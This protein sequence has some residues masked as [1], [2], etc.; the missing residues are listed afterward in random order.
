MHESPTADHKANAS[1]LVLASGGLDSTACLTFYREQ[2]YEI[3]AL[4]VDYGQGALVQERRAVQRIAAHYA[5]PL[6]IVGISGL[7]SFGSGF[8]PARNALLVT[9]ALS[10]VGV[11]TAS[12]ALGIHDGTSYPDCSTAFVEAVQRIF[13]IYTDGRVRLSCPFLSWLKPQ[14]WD[15]CQKAVVPTSL[16][17]SCERG[18][19]LPCGT[20]LS[21]KDREALRVRG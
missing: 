19:D 15:Y 18:G 9:A 10:R 21:C 8:I 16:T 6:S 4:F 11:T 5:V 3:E 13:D 14:I 7:A 20:C 12:I 1:V 17:Y 2:G